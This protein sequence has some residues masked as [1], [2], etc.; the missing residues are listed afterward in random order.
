MNK[1]IIPELIGKYATL[2]NEF[3]IDSVNAKTFIETNKDNE[4][5]MCLVPLVHLLREK[6]DKLHK[7]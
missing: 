1:P 6:F 3:G 4:Q 5:F 7:N 2:I